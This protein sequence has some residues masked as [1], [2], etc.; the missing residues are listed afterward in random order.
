MHTADKR[1]GKEH[2]NRLVLLQL[3]FKREYPKVIHYLTVEAREAHITVA[4]VGAKAIQASCAIVTGI[5]I[6]FVDL[7]LAV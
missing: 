7:N 4:R 5:G 3:S 1:H 2:F 6:T